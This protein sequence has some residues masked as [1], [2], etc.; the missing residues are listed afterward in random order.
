MSEQ[1]PYEYNEP[2]AFFWAPLDLKP[3]AL[4]KFSG[5]QVQTMMIQLRDDKN[6]AWTLVP[7]PQGVKFQFN[8]I[9]IPPDGMPANSAAYK[10]GHYC[11]LV[12]DSRWHWHRIG[13]DDRRIYNQ[14][15]IHPVTQSKYRGCNRLR[16]RREKKYTG[17]NKLWLPD[18]L[19]SA[20]ASEPAANRNPVNCCLRVSDPSQLLAGADS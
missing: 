18:Q 13:N 12:R 17:K 14:V 20:K 9:E 7:P 10:E 3:D 6:G 2:N 19:A 8:L 4:G 16:F 1:N 5:E 11:Y 15:R